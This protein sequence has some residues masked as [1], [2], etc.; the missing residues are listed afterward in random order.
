[1]ISLVAIVAAACTNSGADIPEVPAAA[2]AAA[3][4]V[5]AWNEGEA[6]A[7][8][9]LLVSGSSLTV[10][11]LDKTLSRAPGQ[12]VAE[13][14]EVSLTEEVET[15]SD[16]EVAESDGSVTVGASYEIGYDVEGFADTLLEGRFELAYDKDDSSWRVDIGDDL[17]FPGLDGAKR[18]D[19]KAD[20]PARGRI[21]DRNKKP[22]AKGDGLARTYPFGSLG[23]STIG[24]IEPLTRKALKDAVPGHE[25]GDLVGGSGIEQAYEDHLAGKPDLLLRVLDNRGKSALVM[26]EQPGA[27]SNDVRTTLDIEVQRATSDAFGSTIGGAVVLDPKSGDLLAAVT[28]SEI[29][30]NGYVGSAGVEPF[31]RALSGNYPPGSSMKVV[32][33]GAALDTGVV[34][35]STQLTGPAEYQG[36]RN[37]ESGAYASL[38]FATAVRESVNT[39][40]AQVAQDLGAKRLTKYAELFGF[41][42]V[43]AM[44]LEAAESSFPLPEDPGDLMW[45]SIGQAQD[46]ATP[47]EM[48]SVAATVANGGKRMEPRS[49]SKD[50]RKGK[51]VLK[52]STAVGLGLLM[53]SAVNG[54]TG[55]GARISGVR[56]AGKTGTAEVDVGGERKNHAW[57]VTFA[58]IGSPQVAIAVVSE[59]GG[60]GGQVAAPIARNIYIG[61]L[62]LTQ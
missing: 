21:L 16:E 13:G 41:N 62:P 2:D 53:E 38:D 46:L 22:L 17:M 18:L 4:F 26:G 12:G 31:N 6:T 33:A 20:W 55:T 54:G 32:T 49:S 61:V 11:R 47:L 23:G 3:A 34:K 39:A 52:K 43:P 60:I 10:T 25:I 30:P 19:L 8:G 1:V 9:D 15:P 28:S 45:G 40:F 37:F 44:P 24:H 59:Y 27:P 58:P 56:I 51:R 57:F 48:A 7:M 50:P 42:R 35:P 29:D 36:V 14:Y 5:D